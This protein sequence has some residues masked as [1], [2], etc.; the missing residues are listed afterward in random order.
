MT[1]H[2][3]NVIVR[4]QFESTHSW[5]DCDIAEVAFLRLEHRHVFHVTARKTVRHT[6]RDVEFIVL[7]RRI[8]EYC[9]FRFCPTMKHLSC[10]QV[11]LELLNQFDLSQ[12]EVSEDGENGAEV[13]AV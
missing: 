12:C 2:T 3:T 6:N 5:P 11:A 13:F 8:Q 1:E 4:L 7:K 9:N 10:E